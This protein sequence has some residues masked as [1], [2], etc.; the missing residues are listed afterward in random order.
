MELSGAG[1]LYNLSILASAIVTVV[2]Q[3]RGGSLSPVDTHLMTTF[4]TAGFVVCISA[5]L[6]GMLG[7]LELSQR[8]LWVASSSAAALLQAATLAHFHWERS[9]LSKHT[10]PPPVLAV[11]A[12]NWF[13]VLLLVTNAAIP[14]LQGIGLYAAAI[15]LS[16]ATSMWSFVRGIGTLA[17]GK[18]G[19]DRDLKAN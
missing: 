17:G 16:L 2:R 12:G 9:I 3:I 10:T 11:F 7:L 19:P 18:H 14:D 1:Y 15:T 13:A 5:I 6:P 4:T 8:S